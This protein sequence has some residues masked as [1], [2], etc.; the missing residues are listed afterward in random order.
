MAF[1]LGLRFPL[2]YQAFS[3]NNTDALSFGITPSIG[4]TFVLSNSQFLDIEVFAGFNS[5]SNANSVFTNKGAMIG[6]ALT[7]KLD[8]GSGL[9]N[10]GITPTILIN[11]HNAPIQGFEETVR[12]TTFSLPITLG[13]SV[14]L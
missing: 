14:Y 4:Y 6:S 9:I 12:T 3:S 5:V 7:F 2:V 10:L 11:T 1:I 13:Y 8:T